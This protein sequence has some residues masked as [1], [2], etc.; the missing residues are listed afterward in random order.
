[1]FFVMPCFEV[2][3][4]VCCRT[5][6]AFLATFTTKSL[7]LMPRFSG[8]G[9]RRARGPLR[10]CLLFGCVIKGKRPDRPVVAHAWCPQV[11]RAGSLLIHPHDADY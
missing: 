10:A 6:C 4:I 9:A 5:S 2:D 7:P 11:G 8:A 1:M 3:H